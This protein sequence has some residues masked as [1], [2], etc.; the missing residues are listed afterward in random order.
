LAT[1]PDGTIVATG[2]ATLGVVAAVRAHTGAFRQHVFAL[3]CSLHSA[4][5]VPLAALA[6][7]C[8]CRCVQVAAGQGRLQ[9][10]GCLPWAWKAAVDVPALPSAAVEVRM[11]AS[12]A[13][14]DAASAAQCCR[15][16]AKHT[17]RSHRFPQAW[18][19]QALDATQNNV[20]AALSWI[21]SH[22]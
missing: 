18:C 14:H 1:S 17:A 21:L 8:D 4:P 10:R 19:N 6:S 11:R 3:V 13:G 22:G 2:G 7:A 20:D 9:A 5:S 15:R 12:T 16:P